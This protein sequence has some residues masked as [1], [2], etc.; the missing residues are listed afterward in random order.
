MNT[1]SPVR[2]LFPLHERLGLLSDEIHKAVANSFDSDILCFH[3]LCRVPKWGAYLHI[4][5]IN[6]VQATG[7][8]IP[9]WRTL[10]SIDKLP[11]PTPEE[12]ATLVDYALKL[13][14]GPMSTLTLFR[15]D[16]GQERSLRRELLRLFMSFLEHSTTPPY[17]GEALPHAVH[18]LLSCLPQFDDAAPSAMNPNRWRDYDVI[19]CNGI[20]WIEKTKKEELLKQYAN[21]ST[22]KSRIFYLASLIES[23][24]WREAISQFGMV[25]DLRAFLID[26]K[27]INDD[28]KSIASMVLS[29]VAFYFGTSIGR[30]KLGNMSNMADRMAETLKNVM[31]HLEDLARL[32]PE[33]CLSRDFL[34]E[35]DMR[36]KDSAATVQYLM[37]IAEPDLLSYGRLRRGASNVI[38]EETY[39]REQLDDNPGLLQVLIR[40]SGRYLPC[41]KTEGISDPLKPVDTDDATR[42]VTFTYPVSDLDVMLYSLRYNDSQDSSR[43]YKLLADARVFQAQLFTPV[44]DRILEHDAVYDPCW[45]STAFDKLFL[46]ADKLRHAS[47]WNGPGT[48]PEE[49]AARDQKEGEFYRVLIN[50]LMDGGTTPENAP[51]RILDYGIGYGRLERKLAESLDRRKLIVQGIEQSTVMRDEAVQSLEGIVESCKIET[52]EFLDVQSSLGREKELADIVIFAYTTLGCY[53]SDEANRT[54][55]QEAVGRLRPGGLLIIEQYNP[56]INNPLHLGWQACLLNENKALLLKTS[57]FTPADEMTVYS[58]VYHYNLFD[59][60]GTPHALQRHYSLR[61]YKPSWLRESVRGQCDACGFFYDFEYS[62]EY[63]THEASTLEYN[64]KPIMIFV[65]KKQGGNKPIVDIKELRAHLVKALDGYALKINDYDMLKAHYPVVLGLKQHIPVLSAAQITL[66]IEELNRHQEASISDETKERH[67][68]CV[69]LIQNHYPK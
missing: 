12:V 47:K 37:N 36:R 58:G 43:R 27:V 30:V 50:S 35:P 6:P 24:Q 42:T 64:D 45:Y 34:Q 39:R 32:I 44:L 54:V 3:V 65:A 31:N 26:R 41:D 2:P 18:T 67:L 19:L 66:L 46:E 48:A 22:L 23:L 40:P 53:S 60:D 13:P 52:I 51:V 33:H 61:L 17:D 5:P 21:L 28:D 10:R 62:R 20:R 63:G 1:G 14:H 9:V 49:F 16:K 55:I 11:L 38:A 56:V 4:L 68:N 25:P 29:N 15:V 59:S 69:G 8:G 7:V 57:S